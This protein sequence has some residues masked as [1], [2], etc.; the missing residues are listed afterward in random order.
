MN[1]SKNDWSNVGIL[2]KKLI[3][4]HATYCQTC[5]STLL[6]LYNTGK[7]KYSLAFIVGERWSMNEHVIVVVHLVQKSKHII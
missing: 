3:S 4:I 7:F 2:K 5:D 6:T 1:T